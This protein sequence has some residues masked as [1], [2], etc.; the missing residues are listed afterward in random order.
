MEI[1]T[2]GPHPGGFDHID[3]EQLRDSGWVKWAAR[4]GLIGAW[5]AEMDFPTAPAITQALHRAVDAQTFGYLPVALVE[6]MA[7]SFADF[8]RRSYA[9]HVDPARV[10][11][12]AD[13]LAGLMAVIDQFSAPGSPVLVPT[14]AYM[15]F[16]TVPQTAGRDVVQVP[17]AEYSGYYRYDLDA[18][19]AAFTEPGQ[20]L[21]LCNPHNP[22]GRVLDA[23]E[24]RAVADI[25]ERHQGR[26]FADEIHAPLVYPGARHVP[27]ASIDDR[28]AAHTVTAVSASKAWNLPGLKCAQIIFGTDTDLRHWTETA[29]FLSEHGA[30]DLGVI[31]SI[32]AYLDGGPWLADTLGY[33]DQNRARLADL[34]AEHLPGVGYTP[35]EGTYLA[36]LDC[37]ALGLDDPARFFADHAGVALVDGRECGVAGTGF[38]RY[39][40]ATPRPIMERSIAAMGAALRAA[41]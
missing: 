21:V 41:T 14:P 9:W 3:V 10:R 8:A 11:P 15:P 40:F 36:W 27:Y 4:P 35:P 12:V 17:M 16:L 13:V 19:D 26:V 5:I 24:M 39:N 2:P 29:G 20:L 7:A 32:A 34:V 38:V 18:L 37:R 28:T 33:L 6:S 23:D 22:I 31:A 1:A 30:A 25:V